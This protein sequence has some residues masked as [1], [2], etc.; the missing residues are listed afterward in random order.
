[1]SDRVAVM[2]D[3][4]DRADRHAGGGLRGPRDRVRRRL[5]RR[6]EPDGR[7]RGAQAID[8]GCTVPVGDFR[9]RGG[10]GDID[11]RGPVKVVARPERVEL[12][13]PTDRSRT[14]SLPGHGRA[15]RL[16]RRQ[17]AGDGPPRHRRAAAGP[18]TNTGSGE[19]Y[20]HGTAVLVHIPPEALRVLALRER[21][22]SARSEQPSGPRRWCGGG[23]LRAT[24]SLS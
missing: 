20:S 19:E 2:N 11:A 3:G 18:I 14:N 8:R 22:S 12:L 5:P 24:P 13:G 9:L 15:H 17:P 1:M 6:L 4:Q 16:R 23:S 7:R 10:C 21:D